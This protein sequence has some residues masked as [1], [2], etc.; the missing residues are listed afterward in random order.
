MSNKTKNKGSL[1]GEVAVNDL[2]KAHDNQSLVTLTNHDFTSLHA[3]HDLYEA[4]EVV[5]HSEQMAMPVVNADNK[6]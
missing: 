2:I 5:I 4:A 1:I 6:L 3:D